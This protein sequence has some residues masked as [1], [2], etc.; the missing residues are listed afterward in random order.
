MLDDEVKVVGPLRE[1]G[2]AADTADS[3]LTR[4]PLAFGLFLQQFA[5]RGLLLVG[6]SLFGFF[7]PLM[8][9]IIVLRVL[10][11]IYKLLFIVRSII[12][13]AHKCFMNLYPR[14]FI[15]IWFFFVPCLVMSDDCARWRDSFVLLADMHIEHFV[16]RIRSISTATLWHD[17]LF[18]HL[19][20][21][22]PPL[23]FLS[24]PFDEIVLRLEFSFIEFAKSFKVFVV[25]L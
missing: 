16:V 21:K 10:T 25:S 20:H 11:P 3:L 4:L 19:K 12:S 9:V 13:L 8:R 24:W 6:I 2:Q 18:I 5:I 7:A 22:F 14:S 23:F 1:V 15:I 17:V